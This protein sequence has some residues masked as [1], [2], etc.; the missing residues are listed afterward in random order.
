M[1]Q[2]PIFH[3]NG[4]DPEAGARRQDGHRV[5]PAV[6]KPVV[7][8]MC[9]YRRYGHNEGD[10]PSFTQPL[11][12]QAIKSHP[13]GRHL[14]QAAD[15]G[16]RG[17]RE[18]ESRRMQAKFRAASRRGVRERRQLPAQQ[19]RLVRRA[20][21]GPR[22]CRRR[23]AARQHRCR[24][25]HA[26]GGAAG[27]SPRIPQD[28]NAHKT[29]AAPSAAP[30]RDGGD[31]HRHRLGDGRAL[32]FGTLLDEGF[33]VRLSGQ[34]S[35][36]G[37]FCQ[38]HAVLHR[39][40]DRASYMPLKY[41]SPDQGRFEVINSMLSEE[42][43]LGFEYGYSLADPKALVMWEAQFGDFA[44]GAQTIFDQF[45][46]AG[47][48]KWLRHAGLVCLLPHGYEGQGPEHSSA[49][50]ERFLQLCAEDN[51]QVANCTTPAN[52]FHILRRQMLREFRKPLV[53]MTPKSLLRHKRVVS[54]LAEMPGTS[55]HRVLGTMRSRDR[56][57]RSSSRPTSKIRRVVL[58][59]GKVDYD[60]FEARD[61]A[62]I[63][64]VDLMRVEQLYPFPARAADHRAVALPA[65][66]RGLGAGGAQ[67][68]GRL[69]FV[70][71]NIE[72]VLQ[73]TKA[74]S[75]RPRYAGRAA[76][77]ATATGLA[78]KHNQEQT[79]LVAQALLATA[80]GEQGWRLRSWC[81]RSANRS[82]RRRWANGSRSPAMRS[83]PTSRSSSSRPTR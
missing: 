14:F 21:G 34:D 83:L 58:C 81:R 63:D 1:V 41:V 78:S 67:E 8:D 54:D 59:S 36:R 2:A 75:T 29:I 19:G 10:E 48:R 45:I 47:E 71:P 25:R 53:M 32:A 66:R 76:S 15:R 46:A 62:G 7:I 35:G 72:W 22:L 13:R 57:R 69:G 6:Q 77:A 70:E 11:M 16:G 20:L 74:S 65:G 79:A 82:P 30:P 51:F 4:D 23:R 3:V 55:F 5:P 68:H 56:A 17:R 33:P 43:V 52:Y 42:A 64:D 38:R 9:C 26:E 27:A 28:F 40:E 80:E 31:G 37:T 50:L 44:N 12:Y 73:H 18:Q 39:P 49:R 61:A 24:R 60:L